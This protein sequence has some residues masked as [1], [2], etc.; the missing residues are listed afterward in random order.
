MPDRRSWLLVLRFG[1][2]GV[3]NTVF[4]YGMFALLVLAGM[5]AGASLVG[6]TVAGVAFNFQTSRR[7]VFRTGSNSRWIRFV[8][9][10]AVVLIVNWLA[11]RLAREAGLGALAAQALLA[12]PMAALSFVCQKMFVFKSPSDPV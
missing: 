1:I 3:L 11:L 5:P 2:V 9:I 12:L 7:L 4:G 8:G 10:Y 6:A